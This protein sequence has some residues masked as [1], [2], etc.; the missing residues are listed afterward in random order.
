MNVSELYVLTEWVTAE[1]IDRDIIQ[2]YQDIHAVLSRNSQVNQQK[3]S[4]ESQKDGLLQALG[5][6]DFD[7]L[8]KDQIKYLGMFN[9][10]Q[11]VGSDGIELVEE[12]LYKNVIDI[13][14]SANKIQ[15]I[16]QK[17]DEGIQKI[18]QIKSGLSDIVIEEEFEMS[19]EVLLRVSFRGEA[20][21]LNVKDL[22][23]WRNNWFEIGY[24]IAMVHNLPPEEIKIVGASKGSVILELVVGYAIA[25]TLS[26]II[27]SDLKVAEKILD[28]RKKAEE[29]RALKIKND[30]AAIELEKEVNDEKKDGIENITQDIVQSLNIKADKE[31]DKTAALSKS[32]EY[33]VVFLEKGGDVDFVLPKEEKQPSDTKKLPDF[34]DLRKAFA[35]IRKIEGKIFLLE[36][37]STS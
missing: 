1:I 2:K 13:V 10:A 37:K 11:Y 27:L 28:M 6:I 19:E 7:K 26:A 35:E 29:I 17:I 25:K 34:S 3:Q 31:G 9:I 15:E 24:G 36:H 22:K 30:K 4:F 5:M 18:N 33:L 23:T 14:T 32:I 21:I 16:I 12:I 8:T 20:G